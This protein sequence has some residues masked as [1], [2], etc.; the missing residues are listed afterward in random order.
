M[1]LL[2]DVAEGWA[3]LDLMIML[4]V[5]ALIAALAVLFAIIRPILGCVLGAHD[6][7]TMTRFGWPAWDRPPQG[8]PPTWASLYHADTLT[9]TRTPTRTLH[10]AVTFLAPDRITPATRMA[11]TLYGMEVLVCHEPDW[12]PGRWELRESD[13]VVAS[14]RRGGVI[15]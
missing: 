5:A 14:Y 2:L 15:R 1:S 12:A 4:G 7:G 3:R 6:T 13:R 11:A 10:C 8:P 9:V